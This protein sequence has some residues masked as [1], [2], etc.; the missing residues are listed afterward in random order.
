MRPRSAVSGLPAILAWITAGS[1]SSARIGPIR[2]SAFLVD[3][4]QTGTAPVWM[5]A[6]TIDLWQLRSS[7]TTSPGVTV[8]RKAIWLAIVV[9]LVTK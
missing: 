4:S 2:P 1:S 7:S 6:L 9:P 5:T 8:A 3:C